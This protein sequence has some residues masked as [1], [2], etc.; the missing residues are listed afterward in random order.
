MVL[1][2]LGLEILTL[3]PNSI[4][5]VLFLFF[6]SVSLVCAE[7]QLLKELRENELEVNSDFFSGQIFFKKNTVNE[8]EK[9]W[10]DV[11]YKDKRL[12]VTSG[13]VLLFD[14]SRMKCVVLNVTNKFIVFGLYDTLAKGKSFYGFL[15]C[16]K[17][18]KGVLSSVFFANPFL[19]ILEKK[20][21]SYY[22]LDPVGGVN[23]PKQRAVCNVWIKD[24]EMKKYLVEFTFSENP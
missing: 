24:G 4:M 3:Q 20:D 12:L 18:D 13:D 17:T 7:I 10:V 5:K 15:V 16:Q 8:V 11:E 9:S 21:F 19:E 23:Y 1:V 22:I 14:R 6:L 2:I